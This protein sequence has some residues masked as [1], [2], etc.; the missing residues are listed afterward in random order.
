M[1]RNEPCNSCV[2]SVFTRIF[3]KGKAFELRQYLF[4]GLPRFGKR[5]FLCSYLLNGRFR[6]AILLLLAFHVIGALLIIE[7]LLIVLDGHVQLV[8]LLVYLSSLFVQLAVL[9][10]KWVLH[11]CLAGSNSKAASNL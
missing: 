9:D 2:H 8:L 3:T 7:C 4:I 6:Q 11:H 5:L 10:F 1:H